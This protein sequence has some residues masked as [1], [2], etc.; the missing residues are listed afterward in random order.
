MSTPWHADLNEISIF[1]QTLFRYA[2]SNTWVSLRSFDQFNRAV[3]PR[4]LRGVQINGTLDTIVREATIAAEETAQYDQPSVF[5]PPIATFT[6]PW[7]ATVAHLANGL[8]LSVELDEADPTKAQALLEGILGPVTVMVRSGSDWVDPLTGEVHP[9]VHL[10]WRLTEPTT[11]TEEHEQLRHARAMAT[12]LTGGDPTGKPVV[13]PLRWPGSWNLKTRPTMAT[14]AVIHEHAEINLSDAIEGL[15]AAVEASGVA[16]QAGTPGPSSTPEADASLVRS[17]MAAISN[18]GDVVT[19]S[20]WIRFGY[21]VWRATGGTEEGFEIWD[22]WSRLS[23]KYEVK[24]KADNV[25]RAI[26]NSIRSS[27]AKTISTA[28][29]GTIFFH[30][31]KAGW[32]RPFPLGEAGQK[33]KFNEFRSDEFNEKPNSGGLPPILSARAFMDTFAAPDYLI[34]GVVQRA[35]LHALTSPTG[36]GKTAVALYLGCMIAIGRNIGT[37]EVT[38]GDV[39]FLAGENPDDVCGRLWAACQEYGLNSAELPFYVMP[40]NFPLTETAAETLKQAI[41]ATGRQFAL[42]IGD[43]VAAYFPGDDENS[44]TQMGAYARCWRVLTTCNGHPGLVAIAHP[45]KNPD[46][47]NLLPRGGGAFLAELDA[48]LTVWA[49]GERTTT[50]VHWHGKIRG[51][52]FQP[53]VM[54]LKSVTLNE[55]RDAKNRPFV[56]VV[57]TLQ[58][59]EAAEQAVKHTLADENVVLEMLRRYPGIIIKDIALNAGWVNLAGKPNFSKVQRLLVELSKDKLVKKWRKKWQITEVGKSELEQPEQG[60]KK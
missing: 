21:A 59:S 56:S 20:E 24:E 60:A 43:S 42:I 35:R 45:V 9:K 16:Q 37:I 50:T 52:D 54:A 14:I 3:P 58:T 26:G 44:N 34:D 51:A 10:H 25:W 53:V 11:T 29:A 6:D 49:D 8:T 48:N 41:N 7:K 1:V 17:A 23:D 40:G 2:E 12:L 15:E 57:A 36:H 19:Y 5:C 22:N 13:H 4:L 55:K 38:Q 18:L 47:D 33:A 30:A 28:G 32:V 39:L 46:R 31:A 27:S